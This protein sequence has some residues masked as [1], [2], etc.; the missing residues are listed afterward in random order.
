MQRRR[1]FRGSGP[2]KKLDSSA[3]QAD[4]KKLR[5]MH[6]TTLRDD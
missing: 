1:L 4:F 5:E 6:N 2:R 3:A